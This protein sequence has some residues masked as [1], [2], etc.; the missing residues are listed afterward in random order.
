MFFLPRAIVTEIHKNPGPSQDA[1]ETFCSSA[2]QGRMPAGPSGPSGPSGP[3]NQARC[4]GT[5]YFAE[6]KRDDDGEI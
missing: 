6:F 2:D 1:C 5:V 4:L 3:T